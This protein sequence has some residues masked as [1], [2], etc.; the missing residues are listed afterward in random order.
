M[1]SIFG[2]S[3]GFDS[4]KTRCFLP[5]RVFLKSPN[6][7]A[8]LGMMMALCLLVDNLGPRNVG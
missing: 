3:E 1:I 8:A 7:I 2:S 4:L 5:K 6:R